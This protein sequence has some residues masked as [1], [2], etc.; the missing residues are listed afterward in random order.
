LYKDID[1]I[2]VTEGGYRILPILKLFLT[3]FRPSLRIVY[4]P[5]IS[6]YD[7]YVEDRKRYRPGSLQARIMWWHDYSATR[8][9]DAL[10]FD[11][12]LHKDYFFKHYSLKQPAYIIPVLIPETIFYPQEKSIGEDKIR[13][14]FYGTLIPLQGV[15]TIIEAAGILQKRPDITFT[16]I[17]NGQTYESAKRRAQDFP[18]AHLE[19]IKPVTEKELARYIFN[20]DICLGIFGE[21]DKAARV[22][23]NKVV[24]TAAMGKAIITRESTAIQDYFSP[25][26]EIEVVPP[27]NPQALAQAIIRLADEP[28]Q[29]IKMGE[30]ARKVFERHFSQQS[31][32]QGLANWLKTLIT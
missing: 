10:I 17:G 7:T 11:T 16:L 20:A 28:T 25:G 3:L 5:F 12:R 24:Q 19:W 27:G 31:Q 9:A 32:S 23:P 1:L 26:L 6:R 30:K 15:E 14:L 8:L 21:T 13:I 22:V 2:W 18:G 29:R 4:D